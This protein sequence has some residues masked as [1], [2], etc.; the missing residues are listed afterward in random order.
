MTKKLLFN[1]NI[2]TMDPGRPE[3][4]N[5]LIEDGIIRKVGLTT[6]EVNQLKDSE[7]VEPVDLEGMTC[8]P[9][10][11]DSHMHMVEYGYNKKYCVDLSGAKSIEE[12]VQMMKTFI[13][14]RGLPAGSWVMGMRWNQE[15]FKEKRLLT[16]EDLDRVSDS[17]YIFTKRVCIHIAAA[18]SKLLDLCGVNENTFLE[19]ENIGRGADGRP[20][21]LIYEDAISGVILQKK[22]PLTVEEIE[23]I[24]ADTAGEIKSKGF[25]SIQSDDMKA[26]SDFQSKENI[27]RAYDN[28]RNRGQLPIRVFEQIQVSSMAEFLQIREFL[29]EIEEDEMFSHSRLKLILDGSLGASTAAMKNPYK[30]SKDNYGIL[31]FGDEEIKQLVEFAYEKDLQ[32]LC[33]CIGDRAI[34]QAIRVIG[35]SQEKYGGDRRPRL[36]HCQICSKEQVEQ[37]ASFQLM[38]DIQPAF[39]PTDYKV[40]FDKIEAEERFAL[41]PWKTMLDKGIRISG[42]SDAPVESYDALYGIQTAMTRS[43]LDGKPEGGW[44]PAEKLSAMEA[45]RLYTQAPAISVFMEDK[46]GK[47]KEGFKADLTMLDQNPLETP[48]EKI[49][50]ISAVNTFCNGRGE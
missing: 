12:V 19:D 47:I 45:L 15:N 34:E 28:L 36:V 2:I 17:H 16:R 48:A 31:N 37:M 40:V 42:S 5:L 44:L 24:I 13:L 4:E 23:R 41:Y 11:H 22:P 27:L 29:K 50:Q 18:N 43:G 46:L 26:F 35:G 6:A 9:G 39:V 33:H 20:D 8:I 1:G 7:S 3:A 32:V 38:A 25:T 21:G 10:F 49:Y 30:G 14:E